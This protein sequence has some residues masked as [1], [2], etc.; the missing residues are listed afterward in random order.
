MGLLHHSIPTARGNRAKQSQC[1][2]RDG[3][4][5][6]QTQKEEVT[7]EFSYLSD[8]DDSAVEDPISQIKDLYILE[9]NAAINGSSF[10][11]DGSLLPSHLKSGFCNLKS[12]TLP[13]PQTT[14][15][16]PSNRKTE[17]TLELVRAEDAISS[18]WKKRNPDEKS[19]RKSTTKYDPVSSPMDYP[20][21]W[22][23]S[24]SKSP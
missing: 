13:K 7:A 12:F 11:V 9:Q 3:H 19:R 16:N 10:T 4:E 2:I 24:K 20:D 1:E 15:L 17:S 22:R 23:K 6:S 5:T 21:S 18:P 8:T 14:I